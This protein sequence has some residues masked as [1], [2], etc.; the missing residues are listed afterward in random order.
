MEV[1]EKIVIYVEGVLRAAE[2][3][4]AA[5]KVDSSLYERCR[6]SMP[7]DA[8]VVCLLENTGFVSDKF[9]DEKSSSTSISDHLTSLALKVHCGSRFGISECEYHRDLHIRNILKGG[10]SIDIY[11]SLQCISSILSGV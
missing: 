3:F 6:G 2:W 11:T 4:L 7:K 10:P 8:I 1:S 5:L 9:G